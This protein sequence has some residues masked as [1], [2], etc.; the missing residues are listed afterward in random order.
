MQQP[1]SNAPASDLSETHARLTLALGPLVAFL[2]DPL[3]VE[4]MLNADGAI[5]VERRGTGMQR[6]EARMEPVAAEAMLRLVAADAGVEL[7]V[8]KPQLAAK[9]P[10]PWGARL[11][12]FLPPQPGA[13]MRVR[14]DRIIV[15]EIRDGS[16]LELLK[17]WNTGH[18]GGLATIHPNDSG[19][20]RADAL[21]AVE[22][23]GATRCDA[24]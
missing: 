8:S 4:I 21:G 1:T 2:D 24:A 5:W 18:H 6:T 10:P 11:Q 14:P 12:A 13:A 22:V 9:L 23:Q 3:V 15:G 17:A 7:T 19:S 16:A 20:S